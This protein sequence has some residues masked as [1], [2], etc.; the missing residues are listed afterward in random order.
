MNQQVT[1]AKNTVPPLPT[2]GMN[3]PQALIAATKLYGKWNKLHVESESIS[4]RG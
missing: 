3:A 1:A 2:G 4:L